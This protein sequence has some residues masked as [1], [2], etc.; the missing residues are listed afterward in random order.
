M[1][2]EVLVQ[3]LIVSQL[4]RDV[5]PIS[6]GDNVITNTDRYQWLALQFDC[7]ICL[8]RPR[9]TLRPAQRIGRNTL[10]YV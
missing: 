2:G 1:S 5:A 3:S 6:V 4:S 10:P 7:A 8:G 9:T